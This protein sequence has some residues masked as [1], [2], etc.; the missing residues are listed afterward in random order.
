MNTN[1]F[2]NISETDK[3]FTH[4]PIPDQLA[5]SLEDNNSSDEED[6]SK[7]ETDSESL[8]DE[9]IEHEN[10]REILQ[11][12]YENERE[13]LQ[14]EN[15]N[16]KP[17]AVIDYIDGNIKKCGATNKLCKLWQLVGT[18]QLDTD[19]V[20]Q[21][22]GQLENLGKNCSEHSWSLVG[23]NLQIACISQ[24]S[25]PAL[26]K[27]DSI[28][29]QS[30]SFVNSHYICCKCYEKF[31]GHFYQHP[32][33]DQKFIDC[34][35]EGKHDQDI[36]NSLLLF[37][38]WIKQVAYSNDINLKN[39]TLSLITPTLQILKKD[40]FNFNFQNPPIIFITSIIVSLGFKGTKIWL[41]RMLAS[42]CQ[43]SHLLSSL[44]K[45]LLSIGAIDHT[46]HWEYILEKNRIDAA[47]PTLRLL[48]GSNIWNAC[49][50]DNIDIKEKTFSY[51]NIYDV[52]CSSVHAILRLVFQFQL[53]ID[54][55]SISNNIIEL[56]EESQLFG[57]NQISNEIINTLK[58]ILKESLNISKNPDLFFSRET[59]IEIINQKIIDTY[60]ISSKCI[61]AHLVI[62]EA[63]GNSNNDMEIFEA[64]KKYYKD[65]GINDKNMCNTLLTIFSSYGIYNLA[66]ELGVNF[67]DKLEQVVDYRS[68]CQVLDLIWLAVGCAVQIFVEKNDITNVFNSKN[69]ILKVWFYFFIWGG[70]WK[71][72]RAGIRTGDIKL[73]IQCFSAFSPLF[74]V[75]GK[76]NYV[77]SSVHFLSILA[78]YPRLQ[79]LMNYAGSVNLTR[80]GHY[81]AFD[82]VLETFGV[83]FIKENI[84]G[85][86]VSEDNLKRHIKSAQSEKE[87]MDLLFSEFI[88]DNVTSKMDRAVK[89]R[90]E[91]LWNLIDKL[92]ET[93]QVNNHELFQNCLE[94][95][96]L[97]FQRLYKYY[98]TGKQHLTKIFRQEILKLETIDTTGR[99]SK[100]VIAKTEKRPYNNQ[101][102]LYLAHKPQ[103]KRTNIGRHQI[104][105]EELAIIN[106]LVN[107]VP[108]EEQISL[109]LQALINVSEH[110]TKKKLRDHLS[111]RNR[112][113]NQE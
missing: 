35:K 8:I 80:D 28:I 66:S 38:T 48:K 15:N 54:I 112:K 69:D 25:C 96:L 3:S 103:P 93:F 71:G 52:T 32:G 57:Y 37:L 68:T 7:W 22:E 77:H 95:T 76:L 46:K 23:K 88:E 98:E 53:P 100:D 108:T 83:K 55:T 2:D 33:T 86:I 74:P 34:I 79:F 89:N 47:E 107:I 6:S 42:L 82:E 97:G 65:F 64:C 110:W 14:I 78:K 92:V 102:H 59:N 58:N 94:C 111:Y 29:I 99:R 27:F 31:G 50:I 36:T 49:V 30:Q 104:T 43:K 81:F 113:G 91:V 10:E 40:Q 87:R 4:I 17:C 101:L 45:V 84:T 90:H 24:R 72:H 51:G 5:T 67:L 18:W 1:Y 75:A 12:E 62:L 106:P 20:E 13:I 41:I 105:Q 85:N 16:L 19:T 109:A 9:N 39:K 56:N 73:Q 70:L 21:A 63:G 60:K 26:Q 61:P 44:Y 11:T